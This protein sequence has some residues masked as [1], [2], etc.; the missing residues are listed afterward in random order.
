MAELLASGRDDGAPAGGGDAKLLPPPSRPRSRP[1]QPRSQPRLQPRS[2]PGRPVA[3]PAGSAAEAEAA[4]AAPGQSQEASAA[5][6]APAPLAPL[7][8]TALAS[9]PAP[10]AGL[11]GGVLHSGLLEREARLARSTDQELAAL[12]GELESLARAVRVHRQRRWEPR[13]DHLSNTTCLTQVFFKNAE[14]CGEL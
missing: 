5:T 13:G 1:R 10:T 12:E 6:P 9:A 8:A 3:A 4:A 11:L 7:A 2:Q 14:E